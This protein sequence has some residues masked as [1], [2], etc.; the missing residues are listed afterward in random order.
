M[1]ELE[2]RGVDELMEGNRRFLREAARAIKNS[3]SRT[4]RR[5]A[6][7]VRRDVRTASGIGRSIWGRNASGLAKQKLVSIIEPRSRGEDIETGLKF[8]GLPRLIEEGGRIKPHP[9]KA[10]RARRLVF[11][12]RSGRLVSIQQVRHPGMTVRSHG[13]GA[14]AIR[15][16]EGAIA[17]DVNR[18]IQNVVNWAYGSGGGNFEVNF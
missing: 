11:E 3:L 17:E 6:T 15:Q 13:F 16:N 9:I 5:T 8:K 2:L 12:G 10:N 1:I 7:T 4:L 18:S 14:A